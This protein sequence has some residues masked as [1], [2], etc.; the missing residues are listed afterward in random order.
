MKA[1]I[2]GDLVAFFVCSKKVPERKLNKCTIVIFN[3]F[4]N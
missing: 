1:I 3:G 4:L 2:L